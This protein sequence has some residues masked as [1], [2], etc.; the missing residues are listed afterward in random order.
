MKILVTGFKPFLGESVNPSE[1]IAIHLQNLFP[2]V[3]S[4]ILPV[5]YSECFQ[6]LESKVHQIRPDLLIMIGQAGGRSTVTVEK[7]ALNH[8]QARAADESGYRP[9]IGPILPNQPLALQTVFP[10]DCMINQ[11]KNHFPIEVSCHAGTFVCNYLFHQALNRFPELKPI[12]VHVPFLPEQ[13]GH[14]Q[15]ESD[16]KSSQQLP[17]MSLEQQISVL[18]NMIQWCLQ[19]PIKA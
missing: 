13:L 12:F 2:E 6:I 15:G 9:E 16:G 7:I 3:H 14:Y 17:S 5:V 10:V 1:Q 8:H 18:K 11:L 4:V 19:N